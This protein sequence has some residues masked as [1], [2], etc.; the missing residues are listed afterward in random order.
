MKEQISPF[1]API[2]SSRLVLKQPSAF[3]NVMWKR[4]SALFPH[5]LILVGI[6]FLMLPLYLAFVAASHE[7]TAFMRAPL[8]VL[9]SSHF[10][11]NL[12]AVLWSNVVETGGAPVW[13]LLF[14]SLGMALLIAVGKLILA[15]F[16]AFALVY[17]QFPF[18]KIAFGLIFVTLMLP[19]EV[20]VIPT[21][22]VVAHLSGL[23]SFWGLTLPLM[24]SATATFLFRQYF[25]T[26]SPD[27]VDAARLDGAGPVQFFWDILLPLSKTQI[28]ALFIILFVYG[29]NQYL[30]PLVMT[31]DSHMGTIVMGVRYLVGVA[32]IAPQW[33]Y[34]MT[35]AL[36]ALLPP[37]LLVL[38]L[39][40]WF[41]QGLK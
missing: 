1:G 29:W 3:F 9:P 39:Q 14:N 24:A 25:K 33:H 37:C 32:D 11:E 2:G 16:S 27:L 23:N 7:A 5:L 31:T 15:M 26:L 30:W 34:I 22:E 19:I 12:K 41:L 8:P 18:K 40:R 6:G 36:L 17:F 21:F 20:R 10:I 13:L 35:I 28:L 4:S 38:I